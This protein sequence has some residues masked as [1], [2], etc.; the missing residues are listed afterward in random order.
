MESE[1]SVGGDSTSEVLLKQVDSFDAADSDTVVQDDKLE[2]LYSSA[3]NAGKSSMIFT[4]MKYTEINLRHCKDENRIQ[5]LESLRMKAKDIFEKGCNYDVIYRYDLSHMA[6]EVFELVQNGEDLELLGCVLL[7]K[8]LCL[9]EETF[10]MSPSISFADLCGTLNICIQHI[11][12]LETKEKYSENS[13]SDK[14]SVPKEYDAASKTYDERCLRRVS[15][16]RTLQIGRSSPNRLNSIWRRM[17]LDIIPK[18]VTSTRNPEIYRVQIGIRKGRRIS[19][20]VMGFKNAMFLYDILYHVSESFNEGLIMEKS[21]YNCLKSLGYVE[22]EKEYSQKLLSCAHRLYFTTNILSREE[23][24]R[25]ELY[26][27]KESE[28]T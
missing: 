14:N 17:G 4:M 12:I 1:E 25:V 15:R 23:V 11:D 9:G 24:R 19:H 3:T 8:T 27:C 28:R 22:N 26:Y 20:N 6:S 13:F 2:I 7:L 21:N 16:N 5:L 10:T 18:G